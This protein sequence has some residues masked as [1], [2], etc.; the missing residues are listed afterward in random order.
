MIQMIRIV[1]CLVI[2]VNSSWCFFHI[3]MFP[4]IVDDK[5]PTN[6]PC[7]LVYMGITRDTMGI[8]SDIYA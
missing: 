6:V 2:L 5:Y 8:L 4:H 1:L 3:V 7:F